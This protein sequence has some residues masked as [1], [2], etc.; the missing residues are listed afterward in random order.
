MMLANWITRH[1]KRC[2][3]ESHETVALAKHNQHQALIPSF[4][5]QANCYLENWTATMTGIDWPIRPFI[6]AAC[7][8]NNSICF[9]RLALTREFRPAVTALDDQ[10]LIAAIPNSNLAD[11]RPRRAGGG[12]QRPFRALRRYADVFPNLALIAW[13]RSRSLRFNPSGRSAVARRHNRW[14]SL[15]S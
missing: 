3:S 6:M 1:L 8:N 15:L 12:W 14:H 11:R 2:V 7:A 9:P 13:C 10:A 4:Q 5:E